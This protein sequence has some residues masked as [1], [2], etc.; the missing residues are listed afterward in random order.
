MRCI[1]RH[2]IA[3]SWKGSDQPGQVQRTEQD[4][5]QR[6][7]PDGVLQQRVAVG[8]QSRFDLSQHG[9]TSGWISVLAFFVVL[10]FS[11]SPGVCKE[12]FENICELMGTWMR[13]G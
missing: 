3:G 6:R 4:H 10:L 8:G 2:E 1:P 12:L 7:R 9:V 11:Y 13:E 5:H